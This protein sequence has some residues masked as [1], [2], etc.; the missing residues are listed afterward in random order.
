MRSSTPLPTY[1]RQVHGWDNR[2][3]W[4]ARKNTKSGKG[5]SANPR[6]EKS[7]TNTLV[8]NSWAEEEGWLMSKSSKKSTGMMY[9]DH[10]QN[11]MSMG[12][13]AGTTPT[14]KINWKGFSLDW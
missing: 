13:G 5:S 9:D 7:A 14:N 3:W 2:P 10:F 12:Y 11:V 4:A 8:A 6:Y 1:F